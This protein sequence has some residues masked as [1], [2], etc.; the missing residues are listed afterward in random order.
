MRRGA[1]RRRK[2][3]NHK[4]LV[5]LEAARK[6]LHQ[7]RRYLSRN[8]RKDALPASVAV[9]AFF[10]AQKILVDGEN[11]CLDRLDILRGHK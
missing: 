4:A 2:R 10:D 8:F 9:H 6:T 11:V 5:E 3:A 1:V 7:A